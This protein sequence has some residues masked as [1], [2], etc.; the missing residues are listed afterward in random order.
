MVRRKRGGFTLVELLVVIAI[1]G[2]LVALLL[3]AVQA[4]REAARRM[5][6][7]N[8]A[9]QVGLALHNYHDVHRK[10]PK[11]VWGSPDKPAYENNNVLPLA[12]HHTWVTAILPFMEQTNLYDRVNF[13]VWAWGQPH[14][15][16]LIPGLRCPS[17]GGFGSSEETWGI[18]WTNYAGSEGYHWWPGPTIL[19]PGDPARLAQGFIRNGDVTGLFCPSKSYKTFAT[20]KDGTSNTVV[21]C[22]RDTYG[23][24]SGPFNTSGTGYPRLREGAGAAVFCSAFVACATNGWGT[25]E[26]GTTRFAQVD[27]SGPKVA[28][29]WRAGPH[30]FTPT[31]LTA[32]GINTEWPGASSNHTGGIVQVI[33]G[34][35]S[36]TAVGDSIPWFLWVVLN[37]YADGYDSSISD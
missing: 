37:G 14:I 16:V 25:N 32:W 11:I 34:D 28:G 30:S 2:I 33:K 10:F 1:I 29:W 5:S 7:S 6:C 13:R 20:L 3:P 36:V 27:N 15:S 35:G 22:E 17:D 19:G 26:G 12:C 9:K 23:W 18:A 24:H 31:Y 8:N 21:A 4:A